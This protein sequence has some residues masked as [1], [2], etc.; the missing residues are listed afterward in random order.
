MAIFSSTEADTSTT[1]TAQSEYQDGT[2]KIWSF[3]IIDALGNVYTWEETDENLNHASAPTETQISTYVKSY[4]TGGG[5]AD[6]GGTYAGVEK[7]T[8]TFKPRTFNPHKSIINKAP[9]SAPRVN[10]N[11]YREILTNATDSVSVH[12]S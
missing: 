3:K 7:I 1:K 5:H 2:F 12:R 4:L 9:G 8:S 11:A 10:P 6:G